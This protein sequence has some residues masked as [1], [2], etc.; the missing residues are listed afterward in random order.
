[1]PVVPYRIH[2][3]HDHKTLY[4]FLLA[5]QQKSV[6]QNHPHIAS[7][8][9][10]IDAV[11]PLATLQQVADIKQPH[12]YLENPFKG[13]AIAAFGAVISFATEGKARFETIQTYIQDDL[14]HLSHI[15]GFN[16]GL[17]IPRFFC[18]FTFFD[19]PYG[20]DFPFSGAAVFLPKW[21]IL[22]RHDSCIVTA[23]LL[24]QPHANLTDLTDEFERQLQIIQQSSYS[25]F[26]ISDEFNHGL[27]RWQ[28]VDT[29]DFETAVSATLKSIQ[30]K[31]LNK[32]VLAHAIDVISHLPFQCISSLDNLRKMHPD[33]YIFSV[34]HGTGKTFIG[35]SPER[36]ISISDRHLIS[37]ALAGSA[38]RGA[39]PQVDTALGCRLL[40]SAK[41]RHEH[42]V[43]VDF[44]RDRL[45][46]FGLIPQVPA[47]PELLRLSNIQH[48][49]TPI[50][51]TL[52]SHLNPLELLADLHPTP[53]VAGMPRDRACEEIQRY[54][55]FG[56]SLY[57]APLGWVDAQGNAEFIVGIRSAII[58][59]NHARL[60]AGAGI[61][62][63]SEPDRELAEVKLK[64]QALLR[65][66][67]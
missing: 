26:N 32:L 37:D 9:V 40:Y 21:Q 35:A 30:K 65:A 59:G 61:V 25:I 20:V 19:Q 46:Q 58:D 18:T 2:L 53:A 43:V 41:E 23:N 38:P 27:N 6:E 63:G 13:E 22:R 47:T 10:A 64:L 62:A 50:T 60:Y 51:A 12:F 8:S 5:C 31:Y 57:A 36:L 52:P 4:Q 34:G 17:D 1:M 16:T 7:I 24:I 3:L 49:H 14:N 67:V 15:G 42:Q 55:P 48:L 44:L 33:C 28:M 11:D 29:Y 39:T 54:E 45:A 56:R 66:L